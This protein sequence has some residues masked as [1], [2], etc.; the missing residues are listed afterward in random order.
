MNEMSIF[1][2][3][4]QLMDEFFNGDE[5]IGIIEDIIKEFEAGKQS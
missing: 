4:K 5:F 3:L 2:Q 1:E